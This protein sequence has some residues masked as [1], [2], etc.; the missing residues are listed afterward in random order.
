MKEN[1]QNVKPWFSEELFPSVVFNK[2]TFCLHKGTC[3]H[4]KNIHEDNRLKA[5]MFGDEFQNL[6]QELNT[7]AVKCKELKKQL[8]DSPTPQLE[9]EYAHHS[10]RVMGLKKMGIGEQK[11]KFNIDKINLC[12]RCK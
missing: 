8:A 4:V 6:L 10:E 5:Y 9:K 7:S 11:L 3:G 2:S 12:D 1:T